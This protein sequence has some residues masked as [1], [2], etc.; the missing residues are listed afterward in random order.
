MAGVLFAPSHQ[1]MLARV[2]AMLYRLCH[3]S[4]FTIHIN[5]SSV[6]RALVARKT[7]CRPLR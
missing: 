5:G 3:A 7:S 4:D 6:Q 2:S 1:N